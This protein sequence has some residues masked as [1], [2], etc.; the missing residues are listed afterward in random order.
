MDEPAA[1]AEGINGIMSLFSD[2]LEI[3]RK[4]VGSF[5]AQGLKGVKAIQLSSVSSVQFKKAGLTNGYIQIAFLGGQESKGAL[6]SAVR[7]ENTVMFKKS[8]QP[9]FETLQAA[10]QERISKRATP[11]SG[12]AEEIEKLARLRDEGILTSEE[13]E[14]KKRQLLGL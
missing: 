11:S 4:G 14:A 6:F 3:R 2:R 12:A 1:V 9:R 10:I 8:Q 5:F 13:F 7:D